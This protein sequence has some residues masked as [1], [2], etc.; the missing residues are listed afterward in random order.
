[1]ASKS[2]MSLSSLAHFFALMDATYLVLVS[3]FAMFA[4]E[5]ATAVDAPLAD[6]TIDLTVVKSAL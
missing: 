2:L 6:S 4:T 1:M 5:F 3:G